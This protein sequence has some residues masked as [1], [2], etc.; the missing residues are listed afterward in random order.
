MRHDRWVT[1]VVSHI[2]PL[3]L[4]N[5]CLGS[6]DF[7]HVSK[8]S[9][10]VLFSELYFIHACSHPDIITEVKPYT[11]SRY[12]HKLPFY[13]ILGWLMNDGLFIWA[14]VTLPGMASAAN[15]IRETEKSFARWWED[16]NCGLL[17]W[18]P[19][20]FLWDTTAPF[21]FLVKLIS[22]KSPN[23]HRYFRRFAEIPNETW[24]NFAHEFKKLCSNDKNNHWSW[25]MTMF[26]G[27]IW[28]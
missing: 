10:Y 3:T 9:M 24:R 19:K 23:L 27:K 17:A 22:P 18:G 2:Q 16:L 25:N 13:C 28:P 11:T 5:S 4:L 21:I 12:G 26:R 1:E 6:K 7:F 20:C 14:K 15:V 8:F